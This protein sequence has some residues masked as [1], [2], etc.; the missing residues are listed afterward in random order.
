M[1]T[2]SVYKA[3][4]K[5]TYVSG[6]ISELATVHDTPGLIAFGGVSNSAKYCDACRDLS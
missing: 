2:G 6:A 5:T 4:R 1:P 3:A